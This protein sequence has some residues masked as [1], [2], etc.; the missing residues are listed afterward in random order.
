MGVTPLTAAE[1]QRDNNPV[2]NDPLRDGGFL[3]R[4]PL[5][6]Y[7]LKEAEVR[8]NGNSLG[9]L[10]S[11]IVCERIVGQVREDP[12]SYLRQPG[13]WTPEEGSA[14]RTASSW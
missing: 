1:L 9:P 13:T 10:G 8:A 4:T 11:R 5:S 14:C 6:Y 2:L 3:E 12:D 7:V